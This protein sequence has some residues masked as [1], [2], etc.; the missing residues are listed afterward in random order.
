MDHFD[1]IAEKWQKKQLLCFSNSWYFYLEKK[2]NIDSAEE[3]TMRVLYLQEYKIFHIL[4]TINDK[5]SKRS[6][7]PH[8]IFG[9][10][11]YIKFLQ[12]EYLCDEVILRLTDMPNVHYHDIRIE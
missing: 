5:A 8:F 4:L 9:T 6:F 11:H 12:I 2:F 10:Y 3:T 1:K 7:H